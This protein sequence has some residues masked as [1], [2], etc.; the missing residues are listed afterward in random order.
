MG[1]LGPWTLNTFTCRK[2]GAGKTGSDL[3]FSKIP[4]A[5]LLMR[6]GCGGGW[7][8]EHR[9]GLGAAAVVQARQDCGW[10]RTGEWRA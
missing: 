10:T 4:L 8:K 7:G 1:T 5:A 6:T 3:G 9:D 2:A